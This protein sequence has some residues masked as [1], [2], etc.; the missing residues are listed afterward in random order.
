MP[1]VS[2][3]NFTGGLVTTTLASRYDLQKFGTF[4]QACTNAIPNIHGD[5]ERRPGMEY[6]ATLD[7][8]AYLLPFQFSSDPDQNYLLVFTPDNICVYNQTLGCFESNTSC[9]TCT[10]TCTCIC[11]C[12]YSCSCCYTS[13]SSVNIPIGASVTICMSGAG[14]GAGRFGCRFS[15]VL[16]G[17]CRYCCDITGGRGQLLI[18]TFTNQHPTWCFLL[19]CGGCGGCTACFYGGGGGGGSVFRSSDCKCVFIACGGGGGGG[20]CCMIS[21]Q[22]SSSSIHYYCYYYYGGAGGA[23]GGGECGRRMCVLSAPLQLDYQGGAGGCGGGYS[24]G[25]CCSTYGCGYAGGCIRCPGTGGSGACGS[26]CPGC[27]GCPGWLC[28]RYTCTYQT[29]G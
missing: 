28:V 1:R 5:I 22:T 9:C 10:C 7:N 15:S 6:I 4:L 2:W 11:T 19:G 21:S 17:C 13:S 16:T 14:G 12:T 8:C 26:S 3:H 23:Y 18:C 25:Q 20:G 29:Y 27:P 24:A